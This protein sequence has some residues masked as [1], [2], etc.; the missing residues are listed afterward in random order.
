MSSYY[1]NVVKIKGK[2]VKKSSYPVFNGCLDLDSITACL[3]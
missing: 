1:E 2:E 3:S